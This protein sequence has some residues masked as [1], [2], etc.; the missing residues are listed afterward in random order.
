[1]LAVADEPVVQFGQ[2]AGLVDGAQGASYLGQG[3]IPR[4]ADF[5][6]Q[7]LVAQH[8]AGDILAAVAAVDRDARKLQWAVGI[9]GKEVIHRVLLH[10]DFH[11]HARGHDILRGDI[12]KTQQILDNGRLPGLEYPIFFTDLCQ[13]QKL[14]AG[15]HAGV[16]AVIHAPGNKLAGPYQ[17]IQ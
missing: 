9:G 7:Y 17:W 13:R 1:M 11:H 3:C 15:E 5:Q 10:C 14:G 16:V 2:C 8:I 4:I 6:F 12:A